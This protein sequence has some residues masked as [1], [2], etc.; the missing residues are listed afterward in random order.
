MRISSARGRRGLWQW[1]RGLANLRRRS[2][3]W[4]GRRYPV[5]EAGLR[6]LQLVDVARYLLLAGD[7][8]FD[9]FSHLG[10]SGLE[11]REIGGKPGVLVLGCWSEGRRNHLG[12][13]R[14]IVRARR[15]QPAELRDVSRDH[16]PRGVPVG[17]PG[18]SD[19]NTDT[20]R[21]EKS[22]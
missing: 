2:R 3:S 19:D 22:G 12:G 6:R 1:W 11:L 16:V 15:R 14:C 18:Q 13:G 7:Q 8:V 9:A 4:K 17:L 10:E 20:E 5:Q 21:D